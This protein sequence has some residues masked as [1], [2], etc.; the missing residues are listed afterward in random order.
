MELQYRKTDGITLDPVNDLNP[1]PIFT[2]PGFGPPS[3]ER[4]PFAADY[5]WKLALDGR[6]FVS[7]D[8]DEDDLV[9]G[10][11]SLA[12][13]TPT[14]LLRVPSG[15]ICLPLF[16]NL[17]QAGSVAG[18]DITLAIEIDNIERYSTGGT[19]E[20]VFNP[21]N[22]GN[23]CLLYSNPTAFS[24]YG[25]TVNRYKLGPDISPA[26][27]AVNTIAWKPEMPYLLRGPA[28]LLIFSFAGTTG[29]SW[30]WD[31]GWAEWPAQ[32]LDGVK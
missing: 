4:V 23:R 31:V 19:S 24:G 25:M 32:Q 8:A 7:G 10:Q 27:G 16:V 9:T 29:P 22:S 28:A 3:V 20:K 12:G 11:T 5:L 14:F 1:Y 26:E 15:T 21:T 17:M 30:M 2:P 13:T 18:G 6:L